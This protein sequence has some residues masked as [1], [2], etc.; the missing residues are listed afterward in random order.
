MGQKKPEINRLR[1]GSGNSEK[2]PAGWRDQ[3]VQ[4]RSG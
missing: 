1:R 3:P 2:A 4:G